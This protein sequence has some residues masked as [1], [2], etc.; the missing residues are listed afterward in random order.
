MTSSKPTLVFVHGAWHRA[1]CFAKIITA[2]E[3]QGYHCIAPQLP[4]CGTPEPVES[5]VSTV[6]QLEEIIGAETAK[7]NDV[8]MVNHSFG[9]VVGCSAVKGFTAKDSSKL[10]TAKG[11]VIGIIE[12]CAFMVPTGAC[13]YEVVASTPGQFRSHVT[14]EGWSVIDDD[15]IDLFYNDLPAAEA[16]RTAEMLEPMPWGPDRGAAGFAFCRP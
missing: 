16:K 13:M 15:T 4:M 3:Q 14:S 5:L 2:L 1:D 11:K 10:G 7:G 12:L 6:S 9:G 8:V